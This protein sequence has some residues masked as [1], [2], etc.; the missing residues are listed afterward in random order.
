MGSGFIVIPT[1]DLSDPTRPA[2]AYCGPMVR[3]CTELAVC[4][5]VDVL[6]LSAS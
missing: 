5:H 6:S 1:L 2:V 4:P 3:A